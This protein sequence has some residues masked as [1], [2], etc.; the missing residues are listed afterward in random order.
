MSVS[1]PGVRCHLPI[2]YVFQPRSPST[3]EIIPFSNGMRA[4][5]PGKAG[6]RLR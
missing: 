6:R 5:K 1:S 4:E 3:S 2:A